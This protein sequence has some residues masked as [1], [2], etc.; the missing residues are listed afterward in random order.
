M[1]LSQGQYREILYDVQKIFQCTCLTVLQQPK[2]APKQSVVPLQ[3]AL[4]ANHIANPFCLHLQL[5][6]VKQN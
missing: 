1:I 3:R 4:Q 5:N 6:K 2:L